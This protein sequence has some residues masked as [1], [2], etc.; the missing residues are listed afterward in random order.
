MTT[1]KTM[2]SLRRILVALGALSL[3]ACSEQHPRI[4]ISVACAAPANLED[5]RDDGASQAVVILRESSWDPASVKEVEI[6]LASVEVRTSPTGSAHQWDA[7]RGGFYTHL[8]GSATAVVRRWPEVE[9]VRLV[10]V[11]NSLPRPT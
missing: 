3:S 4:P 8:T 9:Q 6:R 1:M 11:R 2:P 7:A 10:R 5:Q